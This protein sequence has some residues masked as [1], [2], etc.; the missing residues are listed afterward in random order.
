[1]KKVILALVLLAVVPVVLAQTTPTL[2]FTAETVAGSGSVVPALTWSTTPA[3]VNCTAS[4]DP[5][6]AGTKAASGSQTLPAITS[7]KTYNLQCSWGDS[8]RVTIN[9]Q[10]PTTYTDGSALTDLRGFK[11]FWGTNPAVLDVPVGNMPYVIN[12]AVTNRLTIG[13]L[14]PGTWTFGV[15]A[16]NQDGAES[17]MSPTAQKVILGSNVTRTVGISVTPLPMPPA[18]VTIVE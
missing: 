8:Q 12:S 3:A 14:P 11:V 2:N 18:S 10:I 1:M 15:K 6:W 16:V 13:P 4:G 7:S 9:W 17:A 5:T